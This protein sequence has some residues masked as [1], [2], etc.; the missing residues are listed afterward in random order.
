MARTDCSNYLISFAANS[1]L[2]KI[3][4]FGRK[5]PIFLF[6]LLSFYNRLH[7]F[8]SAKSAALL[9]MLRST[10]TQHRV[11][12]GAPGALGEGD[13]AGGAVGREDGGTALL[14]LLQN[15]HKRAHLAARKRAAGQSL[16]EGKGK[17]KWRHRR[18]WWFIV[19]EG[20]ARDTAE[21]VPMHWKYT[22]GHPC[23]RGQGAV[24]SAESYRSPWWLKKN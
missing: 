16:R 13:W 4:S 10:S 14:L 2:I 8:R 9:S 12:P 20:E 23:G 17:G 6:P 5:K 21:A 7:L 15:V 11:V 22:A 1:P 19:P 18:H 3:I 24:P